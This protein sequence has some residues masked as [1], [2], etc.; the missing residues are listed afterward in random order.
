MNLSAGIYGVSNALS[1]AFLASWVGGWI[2]RRERLHAAQVLLVIQN[3]SVGKISKI[4]FTI[5]I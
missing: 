1:T 2:D 4:Y 5:T 3:L